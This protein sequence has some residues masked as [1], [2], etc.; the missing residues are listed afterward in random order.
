M[1]LAAAI[2]EYTTLSTALLI[3]DWVVRVGLSVRVIMRRCPVAVSLAWLLILLFVPLL[4]LALYALIGERG[5]GS[6][7]AK[8]I[9]TL[10][11][12]IE[13]QAVA[14]WSHQHSDW[15]HPEQGYRSLARLNTS[16]SGMPPLRGNRLELLEQASL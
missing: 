5:I 6:R 10:S 3:L 16:V 8:R 14:M 7:R 1:N 2:P 11:R 4:G 13:E 15:A 9:E 12:S